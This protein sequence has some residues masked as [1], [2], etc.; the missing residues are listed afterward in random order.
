M[1]QAYEKMVK[2]FQNLKKQLILSLEEAMVHKQSLEYAN[3]QFDLEKIELFKSIIKAIIVLD[4]QLGLAKK[5]PN[6]DDRAFRLMLEVYENHQRSLEDI[7]TNAG[8]TIRINNG[9]TTSSV[10]DDNEQTSTA[11]DRLSKSYFYQNKPLI[12]L[13]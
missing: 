4:K 1:Y 5:F 13:D 3:N 7:L 12:N 8:V 9:L 11:N 2:E 6:T 10:V